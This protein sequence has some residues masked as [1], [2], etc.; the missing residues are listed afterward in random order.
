[1]EFSKTLNDYRF[2]LL[3]DYNIIEACA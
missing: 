1:M 2:T 3:D